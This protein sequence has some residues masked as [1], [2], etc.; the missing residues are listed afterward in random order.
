LAL[1]ASVAALK[2]SAP[3]GVAE[4]YGRTRLAKP[5]GAL[6]GAAEID[7]ATTELLLHRALPE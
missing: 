3:V 6:Y 1:V 7:A 5:H 4:A 2:A